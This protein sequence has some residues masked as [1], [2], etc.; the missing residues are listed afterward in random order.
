MDSFEE[1]SAKLFYLI[2]EMHKLKMI[3]SIEKA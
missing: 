1:P 2:N 3:T